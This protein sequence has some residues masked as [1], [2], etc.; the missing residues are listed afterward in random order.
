MIEPGMAMLNICT[1]ILA[2]GGQ[3][4]LLSLLL[5]AGAAVC[6]FLMGRRAPALQVALWGLVFVRLVVP[7]SVNHPL[8]ML[9]AVD[10]PWIQTLAD[11]G[12]TENLVGEIR[13]AELNPELHEGLKTTQE[14]KAVGWLMIGALVLWFSGTSYCLLHQARKRRPYLHAVRDAEPVRNEHLQTMNSRWRELFKV[15]RQVVLVEVEDRFLPFT[16][17]FLRPVICLPRTLI[18]TAC[19]DTLESCIAHEMAHV[20][21]FD[22]VW[23]RV[24]QV[25]QAVFYFNPAVWIAGV[26]I[27]EGT[28]RLCDAMVIAAGDVAVHR[29]AGDLLSVLSFDLQH[30]EAP[31]FSAAKR[32][33]S[34]RIQSILDRQGKGRPR[35]LVAVLVATVIG[36]ML[37]PASGVV[38][39]VGDKSVVVSGDAV[40][41]SSEDS[42]S[43]VNPLPGAR[44]TWGYG[45]GIDPFKQT[46]VFHR[47]VDL[48]AREGTPIV[49]PAAATVIVAT[50]E[51]EEIPAAGTV[52]ILDHGNGWVTRYHHLGELKIVAG[53]RVAAGTVIA[54][55]GNTGKSTG[56]HLHL[57]VWHD[58]DHVDPRSVIPDTRD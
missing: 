37:V 14:N 9:G 47:G 30:V 5:A 22:S 33:M 12:Q 58:G 52:V 42:P 28:E 11:S 34:V 21:R 2:A 18:T 19:I 23:L 3:L 57:E 29:Y 51:L 25:I 32:R 1:K 31:T 44:L 13:G 38:A 35:T 46:E 24:R 4:V 26:R 36:A 40:V 16:V 27:R 41:S 6:S 45:K 56:P 55:V 39:K 17:G 53:Q 10:V 7:P 20:K 54:G 50:S 43:F 48:A 49:A 8:G 15:R